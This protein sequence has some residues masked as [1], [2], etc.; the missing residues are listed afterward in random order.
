[1]KRLLS[2][3][4]CYVFLQAETFA[5]RGGPNGTSGVIQATGSYTGI[6]V[7]TTVGGGDV[8]LFVL[9]IVSSGPSVGQVAIFSSS[10]TD[11][12]YYTG[13]LTGLSDPAK[14]NFVGVF[15]GAG[16]TGSSANRSVNGSMNTKVSKTGGSSSF[17]NLRLT[18]TAASRTV[19]VPTNT[20]TLFS[21]PPVVGPLKTYTVDGWQSSGSSA[22]TGFPSFSTGG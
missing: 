6:L 12:D 3:L 8:G 21:A 14:G 15:N 9:L 5:M 11:V 19:T 2:L 10:A 1:M 16:A 7:D 4:M 22:T 13:V 20:L 18:G 17:S